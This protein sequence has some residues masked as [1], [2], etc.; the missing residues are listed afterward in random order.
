MC[1]QTKDQ[2]TNNIVCTC[3]VQQVKGLP[4]KGRPMKGRP[5]PRLYEVYPSYTPYSV[6]SVLDINSS[7]IPKPSSYRTNKDGRQSTRHV[8]FRRLL[9]SQSKTL[10]ECSHQR[11]LLVWRWSGAGPALAYRL[12]TL[13][14]VSPTVRRMEDA[15]DHAT[16]QTEL[17]HTHSSW[18]NPPNPPQVSQLMNSTSI[19]DRRASSVERR[20]STPYHRYGVQRSTPPRPLLPSS[21]RPLHASHDG[22]IITPYSPLDLSN[23]LAF[24]K[25]GSTFRLANHNRQMDANT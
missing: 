25:S 6:A 3:S 23:M 16:D 7:S 10:F 5:I 17:L 14:P 21:P 19:V 9:I 20:A 1:R 13:D 18:S 4:T 22:A 2:I 8:G 12:G 11:S 15:S 24:W